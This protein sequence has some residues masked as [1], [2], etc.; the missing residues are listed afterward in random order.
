MSAVTDSL[1]AA[2]K[3]TPKSGSSLSVGGRV[4]IGLAMTVKVSV[5]LMHNQPPFMPYVFSKS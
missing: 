2:N 4:R 5:S 1:R 3:S